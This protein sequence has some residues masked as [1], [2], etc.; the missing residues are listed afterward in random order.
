ML[1]GGSGGALLRFVDCRFLR[2]WSMWPLPVWMLL[3][4]CFLTSCLVSPG[5]DERKP[6]SIAARSVDGTGD[7]NEAW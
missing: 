3:G 5:K 1:M 4:R 7:P 2:S 6:A